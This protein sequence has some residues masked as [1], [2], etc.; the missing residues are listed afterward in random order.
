MNKNIF[1]IC[2]YIDVSSLAGTPLKVSSSRQSTPSSLKQQSTLSKQSYT[3]TPKASSSSYSTGPLSN[4][5]SKQATPKSP[6]ITEVMQV[7]V[8]A[9]YCSWFMI[10]SG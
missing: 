7:Y 10:E 6:S 3:T 1:I 5:N 4:N 2:V 9:C 8:A